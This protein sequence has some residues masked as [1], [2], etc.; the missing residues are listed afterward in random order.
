MARRP[1]G[2]CQHGAKGVRTAQA[3]LT[4]GPSLCRVLLPTLQ[5][6]LFVR[7]ISE[8]ATP[9]LS[10]QH[11]ASSDRYRGMPSMSARHAA[12]SSSS[13]M[14]DSRSRAG[15]SWPFTNN[16]DRSPAPQSVDIVPRTRDMRRRFLPSHKRP[17]VAS[18][19]PPDFGVLPLVSEATDTWKRGSGGSRDLSHP[20]ADE[21]SPDRSTFR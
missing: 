11:R 3:L 16:S 1:S 10:S 20:R 5:P 17:Q 19:P 21:A 18:S 14:F 13:A 4:P 2:H 12:L 6:T 15:S 7:Q 8:V 9:R